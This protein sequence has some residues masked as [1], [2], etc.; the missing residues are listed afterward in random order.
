MT[1]SKRKKIILAIISV[2]VVIAVAWKGFG[3]Y[4]GWKYSNMDRS[5]M[6]MP[7]N[8]VTLETEQ[9]EEHIRAVGTLAANES[10]DIR[11]E[12]PG[13]ITDISFTEG[14]HVDKGDVLL[15][16]DDSIYQ[17]EFAQATASYELSK[18]TYERTKAL[19]KKGA[20]SAQV[21][22]ET[23]ARL[24]ETEATLELAKTRLDKTNIRAP[25]DGFIGLRQ[26]SEGD[27]V[28]SGGVI[29]HIQAIDTM[30]VELSVA[31]KYFS[32]LKLG[33]LIDITVDSYPG[34]TFK[35]EVFAIDPK[36]DMDTRTVRIKAK[37]SN[38]EELL[39]PGMFAYVSLLIK[40]SNESIMLPEEALI[41]QGNKVMV[42]KVVDKKAV[43]TPITVGSRRLGQVEVVSGLSAGDVVITAGHMKLHDGAKVEIVP[44]EPENGSHAP[45]EAEEE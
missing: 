6:A 9:L 8:A 3:L 10:A 39:R 15:K 4:M 22:D 45:K 36:V 14:Q 44:D 20:A 37:L 29:T 2:L 41:P 42:Y 16:I 18:L 24:K 13:R 27:Y 19:Q 38:G 7:V 34:K 17:S 25:F 40:H 28:D 12:I 11:S 43:I 31:E 30:K 35:G 1:A 23:V 26:I 21:R 5:G 33:Q 32:F